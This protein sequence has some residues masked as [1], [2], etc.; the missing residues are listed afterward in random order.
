MSIK[1]NLGCRDKPMP[2][3]INVDIDPTNSYADVIDN[4][5]EL[6]TIDDNSVDLIEA[7]HMFEH[8]SYKE[9][10]KALKVWFKKLKT[11]WVLRL[12]VPDLD[13]MCSLHLLLQD[14]DIVKTMFVGS[15][16]DEWDYHKNIHSRASLSKDLEEIGF[17]NIQTWDYATTWPHNYVD[18]YASMT[19]PPMRKRFEFA[20]G[21][22]VDL[23]GI[24][25]SL[26]LEATK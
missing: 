23:G 14:K 3:Y 7:I 10:T 25:L 24:C 9:S 5:F 20:N 21:K 17:S 16:R 11:K 1:L 12:S 2:T 6:N 4:A 18:T 15:Q 22:K 19:W 13:K 8:L 26:N